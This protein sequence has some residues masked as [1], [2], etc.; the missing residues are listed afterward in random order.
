[1]VSRDRLKALPASEVVTAL[2]DDHL[3]LVFAHLA[4]LDC[5]GP[6]VDRLAGRVAA[7]AARR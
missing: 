3:E 4:S 2:H 1:M 5:F 6:M 7:D